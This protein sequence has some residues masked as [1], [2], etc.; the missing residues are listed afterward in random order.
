LKTTGWKTAK[1]VKIP[2]EPNWSEVT[3]V[4]GYDDGWRDLAQEDGGQGALI[5]P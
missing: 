4:T 3:P 2:A 5:R 1:A